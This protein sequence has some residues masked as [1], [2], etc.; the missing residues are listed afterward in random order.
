MHFQSYC[1]SDSRRVVPLGEIRHSGAASVFSTVSTPTKFLF[2]IGAMFLLF[3]VWTPLSYV[4]GS[5]TVF[6]LSLFFYVQ[7]SF[8]KRRKRKRKRMKDKRRKRN[9]RSRRKRREK[10]KRDK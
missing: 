2:R 4:R 1:V 9:R 6:Y 8:G 7:N 5:N 3:R 10:K